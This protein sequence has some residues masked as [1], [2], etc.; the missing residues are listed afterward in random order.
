MVIHYITH[1]ATFTVTVVGHSTV[2]AVALLDALYVKLKL[3]GAQ[4][5]FVGYRV[6]HAGHFGPLGHQ[7]RAHTQQ[8]SADAHCAR[9]TQRI[10]WAAGGR[11]THR[12]LR[13]RVSCPGRDNA[14]KRCI[15]GAVRVSSV[16]EGRF[17]DTY[18]PYR[19]VKTG[20]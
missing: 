8:E 1:G 16:L 19:G 12:E 9:K 20:C 3:I 15:A 17:A 2:G 6:P 13:A 4:V 18:G 5:S 10:L 7:H 14:D 11:G